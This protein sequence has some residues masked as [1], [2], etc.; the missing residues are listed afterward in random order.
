[1]CVNDILNDRYEQW[2]VSD[3]FKMELSLHQLSVRRP[4]HGPTPRAH[5]SEMNEGHF[6]WCRAP[7]ETW[8][9]RRG[10]VS[11]LESRVSV[12]VFAL[13][14]VF[15]FLWACLF[16]S[17]GEK[18]NSSSF[19]RHVAFRRRDNDWLAG[20]LFLIDGDRQTCL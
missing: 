2:A 1:M 18:T 8:R 11:S 7:G 9:R 15:D 6:V 5:S 20:E 13:R 16:V 10:A 3:S 19:R 4:H 12:V 17:K 14:S